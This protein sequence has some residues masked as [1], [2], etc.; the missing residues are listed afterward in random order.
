[1][2]KNEILEKAKAKKVYVGEMEKQKMGKGNLI[3]ILI[4]GI[5]AVAFII[6]EFAQRHLSGGIAISAI[7][8]AWASAQYFCQYFVAK[9]PWQV[10]IGAVLHAIAF[11]GCMFFYIFVIVKGY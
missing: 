4:A 7:C 1:M 3:S 11:A 2:E 8:Y 10:L 5:I 6:A 9:R